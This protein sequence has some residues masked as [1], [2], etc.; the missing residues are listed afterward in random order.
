[1]RIVLCCVLAALYCRDALA[2]DGLVVEHAWLRQPP[3]GSTVAAAYF[4]ARN[5]GTQAHQ[6]LPSMKAL[7]ALKRAITES[8]VCGGVSTLT[9]RPAG[10]I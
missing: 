5:D 1:M 10:S 8:A 3:P 7:T 2:C 4:E 9:R 6:D